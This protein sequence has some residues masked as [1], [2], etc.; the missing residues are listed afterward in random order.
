MLIALWF[1]VAGIVAENVILAVVIVKSAVRIAIKR[2]LTNASL[3]LE[4][5][6]TFIPSSTGFRLKTKRLSETN[7]DF[8]LDITVT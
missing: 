1:S 6:V 5:V 8:E 2:T 3:S 7:F 4:E